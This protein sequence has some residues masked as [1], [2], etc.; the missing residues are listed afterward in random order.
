MFLPPVGSIGTRRVQGQ[1]VQFF[2]QAGSHGGRTS[3][4]NHPTTIGA[5]LAAHGVGFFVVGTSNRRM[6]DHF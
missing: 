2:Q 6:N 5:A 1:L 3:C 4:E